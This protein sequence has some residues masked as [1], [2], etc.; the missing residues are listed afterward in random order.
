MLDCLIIGDT[1]ATGLS[2]YKPDCAVIT[3]PKISSHNWV[4]NNLSLL[5]PSELTIISLGSYDELDVNTRWKLYEIRERIKHGKVV[6]IVP[7]NKIYITNLVK[8]VAAEYN[9]IFLEIPKRF[10]SKDKIQPSTN[11]Y[12]D[13]A[14][15]LK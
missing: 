14:N 5:Y 1:I 6:W 11:G 2:Q 15:R 4:N 12:K 13:L 8:V 3:Q 9:D 7:V 10:V